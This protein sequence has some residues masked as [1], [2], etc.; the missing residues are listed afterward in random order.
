MI[1]D[2]GAQLGPYEV[3]REIHLMNGNFDDG[4]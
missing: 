3:T 2:A 4:T 1:L